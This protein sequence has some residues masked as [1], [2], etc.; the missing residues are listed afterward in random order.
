LNVAT[1]RF[2]ESKIV[3][4]DEE[5]DYFIVQTVMTLTGVDV[6][7]LLRMGF[8]KLLTIPQQAKPSKHRCINNIVVVDASIQ[9]TRMNDGNNQNFFNTSW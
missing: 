5:Q 1:Q 6:T 4:F 2:F 9:G 7:R 8:M 3:L